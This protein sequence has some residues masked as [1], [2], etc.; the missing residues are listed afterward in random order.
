MSSNDHSN[1]KRERK[2]TLRKKIFI[3]WKENEVRCVFFVALFLSC[4]LSFQVGILLGRENAQEPL[5]YE[6]VR[7]D[8]PICTNKANDNKSS[9]ANQAVEGASSVKKEGSLGADCLFVGSVNSD[10]YHSPGCHWAKRI[11]PE[12]IRCFESVTEAQNAGY[13]EG[14]IE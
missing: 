13:E 9:S 8:C 3:W 7:E 5:V 4:V 1:K 10:K 11:K 2:G 14:C 6:K 12:N